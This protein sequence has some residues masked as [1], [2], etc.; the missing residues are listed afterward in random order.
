MEKDLTQRYSGWEDFFKLTQSGVLMEVSVKPGPGATGVGEV[1][2]DH[3][4]F[5]EV[6]CLKSLRETYRVETIIENVGVEHP[7]ERF[8]LVSGLHVAEPGPL[9]RTIAEVKESDP[10]IAPSTRKFRAL[11]KF[12]PFSSEWR[13]HAFDIAARDAEFSSRNVPTAVK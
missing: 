10:D 8:R 5:P 1:G 11:M 9:F 4:D 3:P 6:P 7:V 13:L 12:D 2:T